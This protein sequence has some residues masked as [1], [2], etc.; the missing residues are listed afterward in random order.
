MMKVEVIRPIFRSQ[1]E[2]P[3]KVVMYD[4]AADGHRIYYQSRSFEGKD[5]A[6]A[7]KKQLEATLK[8]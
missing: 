6:E 7:Y 8:E 2:L 1:R 4:T 3:F 5:A